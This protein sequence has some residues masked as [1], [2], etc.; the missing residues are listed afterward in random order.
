MYRV[1]L[2]LGLTIGASSAPPDCKSLGPGKYPSETCNEYYECTKTM[3]WYNV[4]SKVCPDGQIFDTSTKSCLDG[5]CNKTEAAATTQPTKEATTVS[6]TSTKGDDSGS[7]NASEKLTHSAILNNTDVTSTLATSA[8]IATTLPPTADTA[9]P[10]TTTTQATKEDTEARRTS[11]EAKDPDSTTTSEAPTYSSDSTKDNTDVTS[12]STKSS[13]STATT[14]SPAAISP[15]CNS[16]GSGKYPGETCN[17]YYECIKVM[18][19]YNI[20]SHVCPDGQIFDPIKKICL[21]GSCSTTEAAATTQPTME[22]TTV[23]QTSTKGNDIG[24]T[25]ASEESTQSS[26]AIA[27]N[28]GVS[29]TLTTSAVITTV[30]PTTVAP[31]DCYSVGPGKYTGQSCN[32]YY[33][34]IKVMWWYNIR[35]QVCPDRQIFD[36][37]KKICLDGSCSTTE[38]V[39]TTQPINEETTVS[40][41]SND[42][43]ITTT[44]K[45]AR[46]SDKTD[47]TSTPTAPERRTTRAPTSATPPNCE[48]VGPGK[49]PSETCNEYYECIKT[50]WWYTIKSQVCPDGQVFDPTTKN[51]IVGSCSET[52]TTA[53]T[54]AMKEETTISKTSTKTND[55][56]S[57]TASTA[58]TFYSTSTESSLQFVNWSVQE[59]IQLQAV[60]ATTNASRYCGGISLN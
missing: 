25:S 20:R 28:T 22:Q 57:S 9:N 50:M 24:S 59:N 38:A 21:D 4:K 34:C 3:W 52:K 54:P 36:P 17:H 45:E 31:P 5:T 58:P 37:I 8:V 39:A 2:L 12:T 11:K 60:N 35:S 27:D 49:Y 10:E 19:W 16:V 55:P 26:A 40:G 29:T 18:W 47:V 1:I 15:D 44:I 41:T 7:T 43:G 33:E 42:Q 56:D 13:K 30:P 53:A 32:Q 14:P 46:Y 6:Q 51:C 48:S 23:S